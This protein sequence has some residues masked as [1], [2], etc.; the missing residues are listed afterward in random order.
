M[1]VGREIGAVERVDGEVDA[2]RVGR[3]AAVA[4]DLEGGRSSRERLVAGVEE[5]RAHDHAARRGDPQTMRE[6]LA[7]Q[8]DVD[9]GDDRAD[10]RQ[11]EP[12]GEI[13]RAIGHHQADRL[14]RGEAGA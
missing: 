2:P 8:V 10:L 14:A 5:F 13:F 4:P 9:E 7:A 6:R 1:L 12:D 3:P 11:A